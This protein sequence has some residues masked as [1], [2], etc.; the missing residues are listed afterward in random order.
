MQQFGVWCDGFWD[1]NWNWALRASGSAASQLE[2]LKVI[3]RDTYL[4]NNRE[5]RWIWGADHNKLFTIKAIY[6][7]LVNF[8]ACASLR[9]EESIQLAFSKLWR[10][11][12][13]RKA[14]ALSW[15]TLLNKLPTRDALLCFREEE[16]ASHLFCYYKKSLEVWNKILFWMD[17]SLGIA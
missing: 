12:V 1:W 15:R 14:I 3:L 16:N 6:S 7:W 10:C 5:D 17:I 8:I 2:E 11:D 4:T 9:L 13:P